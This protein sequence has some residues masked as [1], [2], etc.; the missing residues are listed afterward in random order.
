MPVSYAQADVSSLLAMLARSP[1]RATRAGSGI[2]WWR[3][4]GW[5][6]WRRW[7]GRPTTGSW[8]R[9]QP[10]CPRSCWDC[11]VPAGIADQRRF[12]APSAGTLRRVLIEL[13]A[14]ELDHGGG[15][16]AAR[17]RRLRREGWAIALDGKDLRGSWDAEGRLVLFSAMAHRHDGQGGMVLGQIAV[18]GAPPRPPRYARCWIPSTSPGRW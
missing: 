10:I 11:W 9:S 7:P 16:L 1:I 13:D 17:A 4:W 8:G 6:W 14:D 18:P 3:C 15:S 12:I 2:G 5:R